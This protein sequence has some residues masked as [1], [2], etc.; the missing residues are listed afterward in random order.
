MR[1]EL[2]LGGSWVMA[3]TGTRHAMVALYSKPC[4]RRRRCFGG[5]PALLPMPV[6]Q[7]RRA[8]LMV[9]LAWRG[10]RKLDD[11]GGS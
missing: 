10:A 3:L 2:T 6:A 4:Q 11:G 8:H 7:L 5:P 1:W 9:G